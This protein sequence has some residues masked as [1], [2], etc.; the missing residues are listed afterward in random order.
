MAGFK[1]DSPV[2]VLRVEPKVVEKTLDALDAAGRSGAFH[3]VRT[4]ERYP[5]RMRSLVVE[6]PEPGGSTA[7]FVV[8]TR[9]ISRDGI[10][11]LCGQF[12]YPGTEC[13]IHLV[14]RHNHTRAEPATIIRCR[15]LSGTASL[16][17]LG[18]R[19]RQPID[20][21]LYHSGAAGT[22]LLVVDDDPAFQRLIEGLL[23]GVNIELTVLSD[24]S[25][26]I[27]TALSTDFDVILMDVEMPG[28]SGIEAVRALRAQGYARPIVALTAHTDDATKKRCLEAGF[29]VW[30]AKPVARQSLT[31]VIASVREEPIVSSLVHDADMA[32]LIDQFVA[33]LKERV[34]ELET[35]LVRQDM[36][37]IESAARR[38]K[39]E[40][41]TC[42]F[43]IL[44]DAAAELEA[45]FLHGAPG[46]AE[47][48]EKLSQLVHVCLAARP[49]HRG[50]AHSKS[51]G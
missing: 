1:P 11:F 35:A 43:E 33:D 27:E 3:P 10:A 12:V 50:A 47:V 32:G 8:P 45:L 48:R 40:G 20:I 34:R 2:H 24:A 46:I 36:A 23:K 18:A 44:T 41:A 15:Y 17:E 22:R 28:T 30:M 14:S 13:R 29:T 6:V 21:E 4:D 26:A 39:G 49:A 16:Y 25:A 7:A 38:L 19:F 5:Y 51:G 37:V 42:G 31:T 9:N